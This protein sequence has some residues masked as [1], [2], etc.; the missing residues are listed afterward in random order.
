[1]IRIYIDNGPE[2]NNDDG[3]G[4]E[5]KKTEGQRES[6]DKKRTLSMVEE[7]ST[8]QGEGRL[9]TAGDGS[10]NGDTI[11]HA[12]KNRKRRRTVHGN[13]NSA[14]IM[15]VFKGDTERHFTG[16]KGGVN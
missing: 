4:L 3:R 14:K 16:G 15:R 12:F 5:N 7:H 9:D 13:H 1:M 6:R 11:H 10:Q 2:N 8:V